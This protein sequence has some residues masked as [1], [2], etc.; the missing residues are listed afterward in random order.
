V[1]SEAQ[2]A[3]QID[4]AHARFVVLKFGGTSVSTLARW[5]NIAALAQARAAAGNAVLIV[6]SAL[7]GVTNALQGLIDRACA[8]EPVDDAAAA[9]VQRHAAFARE[10][11]LDETEAERACAPCASALAGLC[12]EPRPD[13][14]AWH[15]EVLAQGELWSS[16]LGAQFLARA[17]SDSSGWLDARDCLKAQPRLNQNEWARRLSVSCKGA[18]EPALAARLAGQARVWITQGFIARA[19]DG[20]TAILGR[21]GSDTSAAYFGALLQ[22]ERV[23]IWTDVAGMFSANPR[24]VPKARL[25]ARLDYEERR[26]SRPPGPRCC[27]RVVFRRCGRRACRFG[28]RTRTGPSWPAPRSARRQPARWR[29]SRPCRCAPVSRWSRW[30][31]RA[32]GT[33]WGSWRTCSRSSS[34]TGC[35]WI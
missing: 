19:E 35:R 2:P 21:G 23:E 10:L 33:R 7:S 16:R 18:P 4:A 26:R 13:D 6:V 28:S 3:A 5:R 8:G 30:R 31:P 9:L 29:A 15:A 24:A 11:G 27:T 12:A 14:Y 1:T 20:G 34:G 32:C 25:L 22:A 17:Q